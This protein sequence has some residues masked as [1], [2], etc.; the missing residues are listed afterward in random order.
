M[1]ID[2][3]EYLSSTQELEQ[4]YGQPSARALVKEL[5]YLNEEYQRY[6]RNAPLFCWQRWLSKE[7]M[8]LLEGMPQVLCKCMMP[9][10]SCLQT[11]KVTIVP[12]HLK[13]C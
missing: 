13:I 7:L 8:C 11:A 10:R 3:L 12:I 2:A 5:T 4:A 9:T 1:N 6:I